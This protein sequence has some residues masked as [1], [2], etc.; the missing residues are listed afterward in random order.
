[1]RIQNRCLPRGGLGLLVFLATL[2][3][4]GL[5]ASDGEPL[6]N[7]GPQLLAEHYGKLPLAFE[8][9][10]G[11]TRGDVDFLARGPGYRVF[12][13]SGEAVVSLAGRPEDASVLPGSSARTGTIT[14]RFL[15]ARKNAAGSGVEPLPGKTNYFVGADPS[16]HLTDLPNYARVLYRGV[17]PG[18]DLVYYGNQRQLEYDLV[19][20]P[21]ADPARIR[22]GF[23][24]VERI[25]IDG[26]GNLSLRTAG[27][28]VLLHR[29]VVY[30]IM[31]GERRSVEGRYVRAGRGAFR[32]QLAAYDVKRPL[33]IDPVLS[34][35]TFLGGSGEDVGSAIAV[36]AA[37]QATGM[38]SSRSSIPRAPRWSI[39]P[40]WAGA[41]G[42]SSPG[43][44]P[45][46]LPAMPT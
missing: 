8:E 45:W 25:E 10:R 4:P 24:G 35:A 1:V 27:G 38:H 33:V 20:A 23:E 7:S 9:N 42:G 39:T 31:D 41:T 16:K 46:T 30:Q 29:P 26:E 28:E 5:T 13:K 37:V 14:M 19:V 17:Y 22:I 18:I 12:L 3:S 11:Q 6:S 32:V 34:Y 44:S 21:G 43:A 36:D 15:G 40:T 2:F